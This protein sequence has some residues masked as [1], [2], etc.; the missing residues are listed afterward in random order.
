MIEALSLNTKA[1]LLLTA[2]LIAGK[3]NAKVK[4]LT[5]GEYEELARRLQE[6]QAEPSDL[7]KPDADTLKER[8]GAAVG[9]ERLAALLGRGFLLSQAVARWQARAIW[10]VSRE[11][12]AY[13]AILKERLKKD[14]PA[15]LYGCGEKELVNRM[16]GALAIVGSRNANG[17]LLDYTRRAAALA[18]EAGRNVVSGAARGVDRAAMNGALEAGGKVVGVLAGD[19]ERASM[20]RE[21]RNPIR[22]GRLALISPY[23][24][25]AG[26]HVGHAMQRNKVIYSLAD[27]ALVV[28][29]EL[30]KSGTWNGAVEQL[31]KLRLVPVYVRSSGEASQGLAALQEK[32]ALPW[33]D[34]KDAA[35][36]A[37][38]FRAAAPKA[39][40]APVQGGLPLFRMQQDGAA[41]EG[42]AVESGE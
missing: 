42:A 39:A 11:D 6:T 34:P 22:Q 33:P 27:A 23:D 17:P 16:A 5:P 28:N 30:K 10:V 31:E 20:N 26:F 12:D 41:P 38:A 15:L 18:A 35:G 14:A 1:I 40:K 2:P 8:C 37:A 9:K 21:H 19:L 13:P 4:P 32:G 24:P 7:L 25:R 3:R 29:A 36:L